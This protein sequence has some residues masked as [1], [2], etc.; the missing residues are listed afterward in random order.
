MV[1]QLHAWCTENIM[2][3]LDLI[4]LIITWE[5]REETNNLEE[6]AANAPEVHLFGIIPIRK[7]TFRWSVPSCGNILR[8]RNIRVDSLTRAK[9]GQFK[10][11]SS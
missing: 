3:S 9:I 10:R 2:D 5:R 4:Q 11:F 8:I 6:Y 1:E 7:E